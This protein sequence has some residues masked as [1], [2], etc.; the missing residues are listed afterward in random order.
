MNHMK[1]LIAPNAFKGSLSAVDVCDRLTDG[2]HS[3]AAKVKIDCVPLADGG[4]G[5]LEVLVNLWDGYT[6]E[7]TVQGPQGRPVHCPVGFDKEGRLAVIEMARASGLALLKDSERNPMTTSSFGTGELIRQAFDSGVEH[8]FLGIG[9]SATN[10]G[11]AGMGAALGFEHQDEDDESGLP[12]GGTLDQI[13]R[14]LPPNPWQPA[15]VTVLCDVTNPLCGENGASYVYGPQKG[16]TP[17][18]IRQLDQNLRHLSDLWK[19]DLGKDV[20]TLPGSG[21]AGGMGGGAM[22]YLNADLVSGTDVL[23]DMTHLEEKVRGTD[24]II[25]G[26]GAIDRTSLQGKIPGRVAELAK[27]GNKRCFGVCGRLLEKEGEFL[28]DFGFNEVLEIAPPEIPIEE[29]IRDASK[30]MIETGR[31]IGRAVKE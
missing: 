10:D 14:I 8:V 11:G 9:G 16:A 30:W 29:R 13:V 4:D 12:C 24:L 3:V 17:E 15:K 7:I 19:R 31:K 21:A 1:I 20:A 2:I 26:E 27:K 28:R 6:E 22:A 23:F 25:T 5:T 18:Q